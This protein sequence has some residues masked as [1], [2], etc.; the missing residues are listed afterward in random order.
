[1]RGVFGFVR[2]IIAV[3]LLASIPPA[4]V[5]AGQA[6]PRRVIAPLPSLADAATVI[7]PTRPSSGDCVSS[8][9]VVEV[10]D[11][12]IGTDGTD[13]IDCTDAPSGK[14]ILGQGGDDTIAGSPRRDRI[15]GGD[16]DDALT[17]GRGADR[18]V[19]GPG[20][21]T[22][23]FRTAPRG[24]SVDMGAGTANGE[25]LD[26]LDGIRGLIGSRY[27][28]VLIG[29]RD[30]NVLRGGRGDDLLEG[31]GG[32]DD[33]RGGRGNDTLIGGAG[34]DRLDGGRSRDACAGGTGPGTKSR[35]EAEALGEAMSVTLFAPA[36]VVIGVGFHESL[37]HVAAEIRPGGGLIANGNPA[38]FTP[39]EEE[40]DGIE[41]VVLGT[42]GRPSPA[43]TSADVVIGSSTAVLSPVTGTV[44]DVFRYALYCRAMDWE[45]VIQ[46]D[47]HPEARV[48]VLHFVDPQVGRGD[49]V[50]ASVTRVG[51]SW[52]NDSPGAQENAA[53]PDQYP[54]VHVEVV[55]KGETPIPG[56]LSEQ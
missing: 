20:A 26:A 31:L 17:G 44:M 2:I 30:R 50:V 49:R 3:A 25:G 39:P 35:C 38:K 40:T 10:G 21:D 54:H 9:G 1:V 4:R 43:A 5:D 22:A 7:H 33:L 37:F 8:P 19:G 55:R 18:L 12:V 48:I 14:V 41:Y 52:V 24:V 56:C 29:S 28:D 34:A 42:R 16:G 11:V 46:P 51:T 27:D 45:L 6:R 47:G 32:R 23:S 15:L 13:R 36:A 53:F